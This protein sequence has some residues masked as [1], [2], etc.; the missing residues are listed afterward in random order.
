MKIKLTLLLFNVSIIFNKKNPYN[1][2]LYGF[3][4]KEGGGV[5]IF[6]N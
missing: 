3:L 1:S 4:N 6:N 5:K 2:S